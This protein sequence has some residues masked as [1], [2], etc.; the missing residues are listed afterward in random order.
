MMLLS[1]RLTTPMS[2]QVKRQRLGDFA[3]LDNLDC[4]WREQTPANSPLC[5]DLKV[6]TATRNV[7]SVERLFCS[8]ALESPEPTGNEALHVDDHDDHDPTSG[9]F[10]IRCSQVYHRNTQPCS[11]QASIDYGEDT[12]IAL[13]QSPLPSSQFQA[14]DTDFNN[15]QIGD[16]SGLDRSHLSTAAVDVGLSASQDT[17]ASVSLV[18]STAVAPGGYMSQ[19]SEC[20]FGAAARRAAPFRTSLGA[21]GRILLKNA[22]EQEDVAPCLTPDLGLLQACKGDHEN[23]DAQSVASPRQN[24]SIFLPAKLQKVM[25][26]VRHAESTFN[27]ASGATGSSFA[28][29][30]IFDALITSRGR[31]QALR[32]RDDL[33]KLVGKQRNVLFVVSPLQ[34][35]IQTFL[36]GCPFQ[37]W[38]SDPDVDEQNK[39][40]VIVSSLLAEHCFTSGD[41]G[42][43]A[44]VLRN[45]YP[46]MAPFMTDLKE[47]W[48]HK[49]ERNSALMQ[50]F[51]SAETRAQLKKRVV[52][53]QTSLSARPEKT[54]VL[55]GHS[56][57][58]KQMI[59]RRLRNCEISTAY[60]GRVQH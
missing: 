45:M 13:P 12:N 22:A 46:Q 19:F 43:P 17:T 54:I 18:H 39:P 7:Q 25:Y 36:I 59:G 38:L 51:A 2:R 15:I 35:A 5:R 58:L 3:E 28:D 8:Q 16:G 60:R 34:R 42:T 55:V 37:Q 41:V 20:S 52:D 40:R 21:A 50:T 30:D 33:K 27:A 23:S 10:A 56:T 57:F 6:D 49:P 31:N 29:P 11:L 1:P 47:N 9:D 44:S 53:F 24:F 14:T 26:S 48:W 4:H 32:L